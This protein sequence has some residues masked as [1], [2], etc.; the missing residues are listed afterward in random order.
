MK[1]WTQDDADAIRVMTRVWRWR[2]YGLLLV[3]LAIL[4]ALL[5]TKI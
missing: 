4:I 1:V 3:V 5:V 2:I